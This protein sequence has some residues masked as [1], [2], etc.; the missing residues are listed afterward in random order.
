[1]R[2]AR[3]FTLLE[4]MI[5]LSIIGIMA[6]IALP[7]FRY[8]S[9]NTKIKSASTDL[10]IAMLRA[11]SEAVKRNGPVILGAIGGVWKN[12]WWVFQDSNGNGVYDTGTADRLVYESPALKGVNIAVKQP[13]GL[14]SM[15]YLTSGR[16]S[17][18]VPVFEVT[19][20]KAVGTTITRCIS[21]DI[22]G[23]PY[24]KPGAC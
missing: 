22:T 5:V 21:A 11:R 3:G 17:G 19:P 14:Q 7:S 4:L 8:L 10:Y 1:M 2:R 6:A 13:S 15:T 16:L 23:R 20:E 18:V 24:T 12:G 9:A